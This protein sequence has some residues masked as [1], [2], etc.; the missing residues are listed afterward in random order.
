M[1]PLL[2]W[3]R[4]G[5][6]CRFTRQR[7]P[8]WPP[9]SLPFSLHLSLY[10]LFASPCHSTVPFLALPPIGCEI[11]SHC[12]FT[13][14]FLLGIRSLADPFPSS[15]QCMYGRFGENPHQTHLRPFSWVLHRAD[16]EFSLA[17]VLFLHL[18]LDSPCSHE[19]FHYEALW[20]FLMWECASGTVPSLLMKL[21]PGPQRHS[22]IKSP[23]G[24]SY[25]ISGCIF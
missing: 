9:L 13:V 22:E 25:A 23:C 7:I 4:D 3:I 16:R 1:P 17:S 5:S 21:C 14:V 6:L 10:F 19:P 11:S 18:K 20:L 12:T 8:L 24:N 2:K 15:Q